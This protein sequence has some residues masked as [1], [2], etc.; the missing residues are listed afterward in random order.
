MADPPSQE[1]SG[2]GGHERWWGPCSK[3]V[4]EEAPGNG[5]LTPTHRLQLPDPWVWLIVRNDLGPVA[6]PYFWFLDGSLNP[7]GLRRPRYLR[8]LIACSKSLNLLG[9]CSLSF[10]SSG[11]ECLWALIAHSSRT[12]AHMPCLWWTADH[13]GREDCCGSPRW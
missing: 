12:S 1:H 9:C 10:G 8:L 7:L 3:D 4:A 13:A 2:C 6:H 5:Y 11:N